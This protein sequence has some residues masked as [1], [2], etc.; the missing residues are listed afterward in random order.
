MSTLRHDL[1]AQMQPQIRTL[2]SVLCSKGQFSLG[3][4][5]GAS[6]GPLGRNAALGINIGKG[7]APRG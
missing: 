4:E 2:C 6:V 7:I 1:S 5:L 3:G